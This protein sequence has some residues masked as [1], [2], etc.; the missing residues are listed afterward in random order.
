MKRQLRSCTIFL[1]SFAVAA[2]LS[3]LATAARAAAPLAGA[4]APGYYRVTVGDT[5][6]TALNDGT[7]DF[8]MDTLLVGES[9][10]QILGAYKHA[11]QK[12]PAESSMNQ[13]LVNTGTRL[14]LVDAGAGAYFGPTLGNTVTNLRA[15]GY[16]PEQVDDVV[17]THMHADHIGGLVHD[18]KRAFPNAVLRIAKAD[19]AF[20]MSPANK[21]RAPEGVRASF[22]VAQEAISPYIEAGKLQPFE[23]RTEIVPGVTALPA[24]GH[25]AGHT[26]YAIE[27]RGERLLVWGD[28]VHSAAVQF[29]DPSVRIAWD[30]D[31]HAAENARER[32]FAEAASKGYLVAGAHLPFPGIG[33]VTNAGE[34]GGYAFVPVSYSA[35][36]QPGPPVPPAGEK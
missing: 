7:I 23:G 12:L 28:V 31:D 33:H 9:P 3:L 26:Y 21:T 11:F 6:V 24:P 25:T 34:A 8:P 15:A 10:A 17:I 22:A 18:G 13:F 30:S 35:N 19:L 32:I 5:E 4:Q 27:S 29:R 1:A 20:W 16:T 36:R 2:I 14:V